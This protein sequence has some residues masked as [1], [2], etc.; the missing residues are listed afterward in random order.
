MLLN[1]MV[2]GT[3]MFKSL[4]LAQ[5]NLFKCNYELRSISW[6]KGESL[7]ITCSMYS[8]RDKSSLVHHLDM[9]K[10]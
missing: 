8:L 2:D 10:K 4:R 7:I 9:G 3:R 6:N 1:A 5:Y